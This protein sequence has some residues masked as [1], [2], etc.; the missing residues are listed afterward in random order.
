M[1]PTK[2]VMKSIVKN[3]WSKTSKWVPFHSGTV[4]SR[5]Y[6]KNDFFNDMVIPKE[7]RLTIL[8]YETE[9]RFDFH[10]R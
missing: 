5:R 3:F 7:L 4:H 6:G 9:K 2:D 8:C 1:L 10:L